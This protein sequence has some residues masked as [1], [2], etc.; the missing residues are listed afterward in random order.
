MAEA[1]KKVIIRRF[2]AATVSG[3]LSANAF[4]ESG[5][6]ALMNTAGRAMLFPIIEI[7]H[8]AYVRDFN[9]DNLK[10]PEKIG[11]RRFPARPRTEGLWL[12]M[13]FRDGDILE[14]LSSLDITFLDSIVIDQGIMC[15]VPDARS[16]TQR[17]FIPRAALTGLDLLGVITTR[18][19]RKSADVR[20]PQPGLFGEG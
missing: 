17:L 11:R 5:M 19:K 1:Q 10:E 4:V 3:Y 7:K 2:N 16:N 6:V 14:G 12:R 13:S 20:E 18:S 9:P 15:T 8:I